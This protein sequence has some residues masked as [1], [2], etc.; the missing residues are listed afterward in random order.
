MYDDLK[1]KK[2]IDLHGLYIKNSAFK[3]LILVTDAHMASAHS[4]MACLTDIPDPGEI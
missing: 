2:N 3:G 4:A 1:L